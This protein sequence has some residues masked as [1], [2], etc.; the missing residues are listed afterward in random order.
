M[1]PSCVSYT[2]LAL[3]LLVIVPHARGLDVPLCND[4]GATSGKPDDA[5]FRKGAYYHVKI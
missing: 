2:V 5:Y 1:K 4:D 3:V